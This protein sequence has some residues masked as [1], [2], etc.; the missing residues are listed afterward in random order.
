MTVDQIDQI[1]WDEILTDDA[2]LTV[3]GSDVLDSIQR[4]ELLRMANNAM[5][6]HFTGTHGKHPRRV[7]RIV[8]PIQKEAS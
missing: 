8:G 2:I 4:D 6:W 3:F 1:D 5:R 7:P